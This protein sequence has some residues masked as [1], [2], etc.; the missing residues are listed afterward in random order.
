MTHTIFNKRPES[1][2]RALKVLE[3]LG[4]VLEGHERKAAYFKG[5]KFDNLNYSLLVDEYTILSEH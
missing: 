4:F 3:K 5:Q 2:D 1:Q